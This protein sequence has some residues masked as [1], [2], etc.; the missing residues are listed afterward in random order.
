M[1][2]NG[3][4]NIKYQNYRVDNFDVEIL[5]HCYESLLEIPR[6]IENLIYLK[7]LDIKGNRVRILPDSITK[8]VYLRTLCLE[9][10]LLESLPK[11]IGNLKKLR[12]LFINHN[13]IRT[14]PESI[15]ELSLELIFMFQNPFNNASEEIEKISKTM[16]IVIYTSTHDQLP[17]EQQIKYRDQFCLI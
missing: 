4:D 5:R 17:K 14:L 7:N 12:S 6:T 8:L 11:D 3:Y 1:Y 10:M 13:N 9:D 16:R 15:S 2:W